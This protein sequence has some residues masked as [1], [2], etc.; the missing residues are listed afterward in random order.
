MT[1]M[2][3]SKIMTSLL[4]TAML[5][6]MLP[7]TLLAKDDTLTLSEFITAVKAGNGTFD[8][9]GATVRWEPDEK[10]NVIQRVQ[11]PNAQYQLFDDLED[12]TI[13]NV[14]FEYV[15]ADIPAHSDAWGS[16]NKDWSKDQIRN[17]EFQLLN[18]GNVTIENC[19]FDKLIISPFGD[20][21]NRSNDAN[22][23]VSIMGSTFK[24]V[25][26]AYAIKDIYPASAVIS[27]NDFDNCSGGIYFEGSIERKTLTITGNTFD[28]ID[29]YAASG[30]ENTRGIIQFSSKCVL[31]TNTDLDVSGNQ[32][33]GNLVKD[34][35]NNNDLPVIRQLCDLDA[36]T[37]NGW[38]PGKAFS[39][40]IDSANIKLPDMPSGEVDG[41]TYI[42]RG[43]AKAADYIGPTDLTNEDLLIAAGTSVETG[44]YY[45]VWEPKYTI[46]YTDG[47]ADEEIFAD[48]VY[49]DL[50]SGS[51]TPSF[52][53]I[54]K[55]AGY[56]FLGWS[57]EVSEKVNDTLTY[58]ATWGEDVNGNGQPDSEEQK[59]TVTYTDGIADEEIFA[60]QVSKGLLS[61]MKTPAFD[62]EP[63]RDGY[64]FTGW[65]PTI[66]ETVTKDVVYTATW[67]KVEST[68]VNP[69][70][71][72]DPTKPSTPSASADTSETPQTGN[73]NSMYY[74]FAIMTIGF[75]AFVFACYAH[76]QEHDMR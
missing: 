56:V 70:E 23:Q 35:S 61:G 73:E 43:W 5:M 55:R 36:V 41:V 60:D 42:F 4:I 50:S 8:G 38:E 40:K 34:E 20:Q 53:G 51:K 2:K 29:Q 63:K 19:T 65:T 7:N 69:T 21:N 62:G 57:P 17:A 25:Y 6:I 18:K 10:V 45:A 64:Q 1:K 66:S 58:V 54:P 39:I 24:N 49:K 31:S 16:N 30:K 32:I 75:G 68:V 59:Y 9:Q 37:M 67:E 48:Q 52:D 28:N 26:N 72:E 74:W 14:N 22:R 44:Y 46:T 12:I 3:I 27:D 47:V 71:N 15:P 33:S 13:S 11:E 76:H